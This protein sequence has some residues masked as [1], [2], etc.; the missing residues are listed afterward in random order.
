MIAP[1]V[2]EFLIGRNAEFTESWHPRAATALAEAN[3]D[4]TRPGELI[5]TV[6]VHLR[7]S[8]ALVAM[9]AD[10][11]IDWTALGRL[12]GTTDLQ[13][14]TESE[15]DRLFPALEVGAIPPLGPL[16]NLPVFMDRRLAGCDKVAFNAGSHS[17]TIHMTNKQFQDLVKPVL[18][19]LAVK[20]QPAR[21]DHEN[22][23][24]Q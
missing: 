3:K 2:R 15:I 22:A 11:R 7:D 1:A 19:N 8:F 14:A 24:V 17:N 6:L 12:A 9:P 5:K 21:G 10:C 13:L 20:L 23:S 16:F 18:G 4:H